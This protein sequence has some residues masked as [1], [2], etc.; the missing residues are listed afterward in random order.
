MGESPGIHGILMDRPLSDR[1]VI[2]FCCVRGLWSLLFNPSN[3]ISSGAGQ[4]TIG[5]LTMTI[6][7]RQSP[8]T[9]VGQVHRSRSARE[10]GRLFA[11]TGQRI[12][13]VSAVG[14]VTCVR[15]RELPDGCYAPLAHARLAPA[16]GLDE[17]RGLP[18]L[19]HSRVVP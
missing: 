6:L 14:L 17:A 12:E 15:L 13:T 16:L 8:Q 4:I 19:R 2:G 18:P 3:R 1:S 5:G 9:S 11:N 7:E 10:A